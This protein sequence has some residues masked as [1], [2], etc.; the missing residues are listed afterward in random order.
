MTLLLAARARTHILLTADGRCV[1][2]N[3]GVRTT[4]SDT[5]QKIFPVDGCPLALVQHGENILNGHPV[6][7]VLTPLC[8]DHA[9]TLATLSVRQFS[10][11]VAQ[12]LDSMVSATLIRI[13]ESKNCGFWVCG[14]DG[15]C[16]KPQMYEVIWAKESPTDVSQRV[17]PRG[18]LLMGGDGAQF[19]KEF[20]KKPIDDRLSW[21]Q[22]FGADLQYS[23]DLHQ[24]L[25]R[26]ANDA[27]VKRGMDV[28]G[29]HMH[30][31]ALT[32]S[33]WEWIIPPI[34]AS[35]E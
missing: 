31:L 29:G 21:R 30:Q 20:L 10:V 26:R 7:R 32:S 35:A 1:K 25:C 8:R 6:S 14:I 18:D 24:E 22:V 27:Q 5:L 12:E 4:K 28:F 17:I 16:Q 9:V 2:T 34:D 33:G 13:A 11:L 15:V 19:I 23:R 3:R